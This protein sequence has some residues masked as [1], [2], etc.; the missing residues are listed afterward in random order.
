MTVNVFYVLI[1]ILIMTVSL[2]SCRLSL[3]TFGRERSQVA[4]LCT[5]HIKKGSQLNVF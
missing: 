4:G 1:N 2:V 3:V 5:V